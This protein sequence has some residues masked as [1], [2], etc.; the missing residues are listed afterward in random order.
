M[1]KIT[2]PMGKL[3]DIFFQ[4]KKKTKGYIS[5]TTDATSTL[6]YVRAEHIDM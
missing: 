4:K 1:G 5:C 6:V 2:N 3:K